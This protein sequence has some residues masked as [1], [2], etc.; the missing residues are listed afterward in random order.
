M[1]AYE[2]MREAVL[3][4]RRFVFAANHGQR[5]ILVF[6][7]IREPYFI[8]AKDTLAKIDAALAEPARICDK[9][10]ANELKLQV[11]AGL[12]YQIKIKG[13]NIRGLEDLLKSVAGAVID[14]A[15]DTNEEGN[16]ND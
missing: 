6:D 3:E 13:F 1:N 9:L 16:T 4:V 12:A 2:K 11:F 10:S 15:Y 5:D 8:R 14:I 7:K